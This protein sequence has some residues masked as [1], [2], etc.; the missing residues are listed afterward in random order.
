MT[1]YLSL[2]DGLLLIGKLGD[3]KIRDLGMLD[4]A[5]HRPRSGY[6]GIDAYPALPLKAAALL[7][8]VTMNHALIDGN[9][10]SAWMLCGA[11]LLLNGH[12]S[13]LSHDEAVALMLAVARGE[14]DVESIAQGLRVV[15]D[16]R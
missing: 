12:R 14:L 4:S 13:D 6:G 9:K 5:L 7:H 8:S 10:R 15:P 16:G 1:D 3:L 11:F 2:E